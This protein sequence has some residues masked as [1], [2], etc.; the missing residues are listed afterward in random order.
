MMNKEE[1][2]RVLDI[3][4]SFLLLSRFEGCGED[5]GK[6]VQMIHWDDP[7]F[8]QHLS[9]HRIYPGSMIQEGALQSAAA[10]IH[11]CSSHQGLAIIHT[12]SARLFRPVKQRDLVTVVHKVKLTKQIRDLC[13][14][15]AE[16]HGPYGLISKY[17]F[18]YVIRT[19]V[20]DSSE[21]LD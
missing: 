14:I 11:V 6:G 9:N 7:L 1:L 19:R 8:N 21:K 12:V 5:S 17:Q 10:L 4:G 2:S 15:K 3:H 13:E 18:G 16:S 20:S